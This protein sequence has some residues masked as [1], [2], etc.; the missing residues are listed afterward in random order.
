MDGDL[1][2]GL[3]EEDGV[4][5]DAFLLDI[6]GALA[7]ADLL[8]TASAKGRR[9]LSGLRSAADVH[10]LPADPVAVDQSV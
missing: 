10:Q 7:E 9:H 2:R 3:G 8:P 1:R 5:R 4:A 6:R